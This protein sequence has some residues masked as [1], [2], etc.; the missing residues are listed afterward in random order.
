MLLIGSSLGGSRGTVSTAPLRWLGR[1]SYEIYLSHA[2]VYV[3]LLSGVERARPAM[4][5]VR[6]AAVVIVA[7]L[8]GFVFSRLISE[9][10]NRLLRGG[11]LPAQLKAGSAG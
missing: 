2:F 10:M 8:L 7:G 11:P 9:P 6:V 3:G 5:A 4:V 1:Y